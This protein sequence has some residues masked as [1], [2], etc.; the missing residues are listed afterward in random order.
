MK[1]EFLNIYVQIFILGM[2]LI[3]FVVTLFR[4]RRLYIFY[5]S[6]Y[7]ERMSVVPCSVFVFLLLFSALVSC[8]LVYARDMPIGKHISISKGYSRCFHENIDWY[9]YT[10]N[11]N[12]VHSIHPPFTYHNPLLWMNLNEL[13][14]QQVA[15]S[16]GL[17]ERRYV[18]NGP[19]WS[20]VSLLCDP[21]ILR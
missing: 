8:A 17:E 19:W 11:T 21:W 7:Q 16:I 14:P 10:A 5:P 3:L 13:P 12:T 4:K 9:A 15:D 20:W 1:N 6:W 2:Y 18:L